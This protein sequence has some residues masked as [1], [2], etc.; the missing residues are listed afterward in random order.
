MTQGRKVI[1]LTDNDTLLFGQKYYGEKMANVPASYLIYVY[2]NY[3]NIPSNLK[4]YIEDNETDLRAEA[5]ET[6]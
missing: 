6:E 1:A 3:K 4:A 5:G 2:D